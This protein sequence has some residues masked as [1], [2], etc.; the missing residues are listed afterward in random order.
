MMTL[1]LSCKSNEKCGIKKYDVVLSKITEKKKPQSNEEF[2]NEMHRN[3]P[4]TRIF[5]LILKKCHSS[6]L[7]FYH[8]F[9]ISYCNLQVFTLTF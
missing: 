8:L 9:H 7:N 3:F 1:Y 6:F 4:N 2:K 5:H